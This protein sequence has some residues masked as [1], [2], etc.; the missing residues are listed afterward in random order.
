MAAQGW[1]RLPSL[2][3]AAGLGWGAARAVA[4]LLAACLAPISV[5]QPIDGQETAGWGLRWGAVLAVAMASGAVLGPPPPAGLRRILAVVVFTAVL[6][7]GLTLLVAALAIL[8]V[9]LH[10]WGQAWELPSRAGYA[11]RVA[12]LAAVEI[13]GPPCAAVGGWRLFRRRM[14]QAR[15]QGDG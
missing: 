3:W 4:A 13:L 7:L 10:L 6:V 11:A 12:A 9:R 14:G 8:A 1:R 2:L 15:D 5:D